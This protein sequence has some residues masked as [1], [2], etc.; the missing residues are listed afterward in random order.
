[1]S[2]ISFVHK[3]RCQQNRSIL[4]LLNQQI[5]QSSSSSRIQ[6]TGR[7][8]ANNNFRVSA[9]GNSN[10]KLPLHPSGKLIAQSVALIFH[11]QHG[12]VLVRI[13]G[14]FLLILDAFETTEESEMFLDCQLIKEHVVLRTN[15]ERFANVRHAVSNIFSIDIS[16]SGRWCDEPSQ[17]R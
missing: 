13:V 1:M 10:G 7:L 11:L 5:P 14:D 17:H 3:M 6:T 2:Y 15:A 9:Q 12:N 8:I 4:L 16:C